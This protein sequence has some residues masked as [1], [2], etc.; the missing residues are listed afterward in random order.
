MS[1]EV[2]RG[3]LLV[4][5]YEVLRVDF[6]SSKTMSLTPPSETVILIS[7]VTRK[8]RR[9][10]R[11]ASSDMRFEKRISVMV[12]HLIVGVSNVGAGEVAIGYDGVGTRR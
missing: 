2:F 4:D 1:N 7:P 6:L 9:Y 11:T 5:S 3:C 8:P 10:W 12:E